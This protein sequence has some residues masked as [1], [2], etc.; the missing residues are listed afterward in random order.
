MITKVRKIL[1]VAIV[2]IS[3]S[4][5]AKAEEPEDGTI[6][7]FS[8]E[9][10]TNIEVSAFEDKQIAKVVYFRIDASGIFRELAA[11]SCEGNI[12]RYS[13]D[14]ENMISGVYQVQVYF[15]D[16]NAPVTKSFVL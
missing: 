7:V 15:E 4:I 11:D 14:N 5:N 6:V 1:F 2:A 12:C 13:I 3:I 10:S 16:K 9:N 8:T